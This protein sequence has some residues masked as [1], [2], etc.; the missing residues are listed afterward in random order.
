LIC[1]RPTCGHLPLHQQALAWGVNKK[2]KL[3]QLADNFMPSSGSLSSH[4][5]P[6]VHQPHQRPWRRVVSTMKKTLR[7]TAMSATAFAPRP[8]AM[9]GGLDRLRLRVLRRCL[10][11]GWRRT[12]RLTWPRWSSAMRACRRPGV[13]RGPQVPAGHRRPGA[14][15]PVG[16]DLRRTHLAGGGRGVGHAVGAGG[17]VAGAAGGFSWRLDRCRAD[18]PVRRDAVLPGHSGGP[19]DCGCGPRAVPQCARVAGVWRADLFHLAHRL[20]AVR[21]HGARLHAGGAQQ[22]IRAGGARDGRAPL[23]IMRGMCCPT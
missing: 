2:V 21:A 14:R 20:G 1:I 12:T 16:A 11:A 13:S 5:T 7:W 18:A 9:A 15:H 4:K 19:A 8:V 23:R 6:I 10:P 22:G 17:V 3:V